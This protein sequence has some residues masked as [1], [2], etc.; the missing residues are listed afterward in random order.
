MENTDPSVE[1]LIHKGWSD[2]TKALELIETGDFYDAAEKSWS[3]IE[4][5]RKACLVAM[6]IPYNIAK[7]VKDGVPLFS[8]ILESLGYNSL[9]RMY[10]YFDSRLHILGFYERVTPEETIKKIIYDE[11]R[12]WLKDMENAIEILK[13]IDLSG[14]VVLLK[15]LNK[16]RQEA[17]K[18][19]M[20]H[21]E[22]KSQI[23]EIISKS[24][25]TIT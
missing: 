19:S 4:N 8:R 10:F 25:Q 23:A 11:V 2:Y 13:K 17:L 14:I 22:I 20:N 5:F 7:S 21:A 6:K 3:A 16:A 12:S 15:K 24:L 18:A 1:E 9:V